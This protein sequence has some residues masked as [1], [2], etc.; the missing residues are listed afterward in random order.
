MKRIQVRGYL[1]AILSDDLGCS[2][3]QLNH[4]F[5]AK[6]FDALVVDR[7]HTRATHTVALYFIYF[8]E[9]SCVDHTMF[10]PARSS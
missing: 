5:F 7:S 4:L 9:S 6:V 10:D 8:R 3:R 1:V 2:R